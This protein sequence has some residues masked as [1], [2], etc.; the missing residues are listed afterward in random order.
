METVKRVAKNYPRLTSILGATSV[1]GF[2]ILL[3]RVHKV[4]HS[5]AAQQ[6][7]Y[8][9]LAEWSKACFRAPVVPSV[10][11]PSSGGVR[12]LQWNVLADGLARDGFLTPPALK[13]WPV[14]RDNIPL[15]DGSAV[16]LTT[17]LNELKEVRSKTDKHEMEAALKEIKKKYASEASE[18]NTELLLDWTGRWLRMEAYIIAVDPD[19]ITL[20]EVDRWEDMS[21]DLALLGYTGLLSGSEPPTREAINPHPILSPT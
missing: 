4:Q 2:A 10:A 1:V 19:I 9:A 18:Q 20:Q 5:S 21:R 3:Y 13:L 7:V 11:A 8:R 17:L 15:S 12:V 16:P 14:N 6:E